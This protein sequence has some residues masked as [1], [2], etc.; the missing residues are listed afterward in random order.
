MYLGI[1]GHGDYSR[2]NLYA[3]NFYINSTA[4]GPYLSHKKILPLSLSLCPLVVPAAPSLVSLRGCPGP[5]GPRGSS[6]FSPPSSEG[7]SE[8][9]RDDWD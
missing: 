5:R 1:E 3:S 6:T 4:V 8:A 7:I 9:S 2:I